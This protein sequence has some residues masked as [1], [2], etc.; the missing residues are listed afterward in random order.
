MS[1]RSFFRL[2]STT[3]A[4]EAGDKSIHSL[5]PPPGGPAFATTRSVAPEA[6]ATRSN[7]T[8]FTP[9]RPFDSSP[10]DDDEPRAVGAAQE[11]GDRGQPR[12]AM[13]SAPP[14]VLVN[15]LSLSRSLEVDFSPPPP[16]SGVP[17]LPVELEPTLQKAAA[18][19][20]TYV[21]TGYTG[22]L[23]DAVAA[24]KFVLSNPTV[25]V[26]QAEVRL[27][28]VE[29]LAIAYMHRH[30]ARGD[31]PDLDT[32][33][34]YFLEILDAEPV[35][36]GQQIRVRGEVG[37]A[38][39]QR[40]LNLAEA[41]DVDRAVL[42]YRERIDLTTPDRSDYLT[43]LDDLGNALQERY[44]VRRDRHDL[45]EAISHFGAAL[46]ASAADSLP[47]ADLLNDL[48]IALEYRYSATGDVADLKRAVTSL[49]DAVRIIALTRDRTS[50]AAIENGRLA[51][52]LARILRNLYSYTDD[53]EYLK[54]SIAAYEESVASAPPLSPDWSR[55][56][57]KLA[58]VL[59]D[60]Y[61]RTAE[62]SF[63]ERAVEAYRRSF[64][65]RKSAPRFLDRLDEQAVR[66]V[67]DRSVEEAAR[68][69]KYGQR[70]R[71]L[72]CESLK[73]DWSQGVAVVVPSIPSTD[74]EHF[75]VIASE[76]MLAFAAME[77]ALVT[78]GC[79]PHQIDTEI[80]EEVV[81]GDTRNLIVICSPKRNPITKAVLAE[82]SVSSMTTVEMFR[83]GGVTGPETDGRPGRPLGERWA[84]RVG[85]RVM[86]SPSY[87]QMVA[88]QVQGKSPM[89]GPLDD[90]ALLARFP[91][92]WNPAASVII[93]AG[94][95]AFGT[96][97]AARYLR[98]HGAELLQQT[99]GRDFAMILRIRTESFRVETNPDPEFLLLLESK[100][101]RGT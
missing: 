20:A 44:V 87:E 97:G 17:D 92:P 33:I 35:D 12:S 54:Q 58:T 11:H 57:G 73:L 60:G 46:L 98:E 18:A 4:Y 8:D 48:A 34:Y 88:L 67:E 47:H 70:R 27:A 51:A 74:N 52:K 14:R 79:P 66:L 82:P 22:A 69:W 91:S 30:W 31:A 78:A 9:H 93:V 21:A 39:R 19:E 75:R 65:S 100:P 96:W 24:W 55:R 26:E 89:K 72:L 42:L 84:M 62:V 53:V 28:V 45:D 59:A 85:D 81:I 95:R 83:V 37:L 101:T 43:C 23:D 80:A 41:S 16:L 13:P 3:G 68:L 38:L 56:L 61:A 77:E 10:P 63:L 99:E 49:Q 32:A 36:R 64:S 94:L 5:R 40:H 76:D 2:P 1:L 29:S 7:G 15:H 25:T 71:R 6:P 90:Y 86:E 50:I